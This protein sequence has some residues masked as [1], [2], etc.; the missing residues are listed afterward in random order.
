M[1]T[2]QLNRHR[3]AR[4]WLG[5][6]PNLYYPSSEVLQTEVESQI[7][8]F[9]LDTKGRKVALELIIPAAGR[10]YYGLLGATHYQQVDS[11]KLLSTLDEDCSLPLAKGGYWKQLRVAVSVGDRVK[12]DLGEEK[13]E[14]ALAAKIDR[15]YPGLPLEYATS[16]LEGVV[17][18]EKLLPGGLLE[19]NCAAHGVF[20]SSPHIFR[21][22]THTLVQLLACPEIESWSSEKLTEVVSASF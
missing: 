15:V 22:L 9:N 16:V 14:W 19:F 18:A 21:Q 10:A 3:Q 20:G 11:I 13:L 4:I 12:S 1:I 17:G 6:F 2:L 7:L 8:P 5:K